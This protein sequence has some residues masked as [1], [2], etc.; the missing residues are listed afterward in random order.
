MPDRRTEELLW[1]PSPLIEIARYVLAILVVATFGSAATL[2]ALHFQPS[3]QVASDT[4]DAVLLDLPPA[5]ESSAPQRDVN[6]GPEQQA[7]Q[8]AA[9][10]APA[11]PAEVKPVPP[12]P[13]PPDPKPEPPQDPTDQKIDVAPAPRPDAAVMPPPKPPD[14]PPPD[15]PPKDDKPDLL[16][17]EVAPPLPP[18]VA[19]ATA[20]EETGVSGSAAP[21]KEA[22]PT[23][24]EAAHARAAKAI[25][26]W[27]R[28]MLGRL[29]VA[30]SGMHTGGEIGSVEVVF[31]IDHAGTIVTSRVARGSGS[32]RM[33]QAA[34]AL[35]QRASPFPRPPATL[36]ARELTFRVPIVFARRR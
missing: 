19:A 35:V 34:L 14:I 20:Q 5:V 29:Q 10:V 23:D 26:R 31:S 1:R 27:Q 22:E 6:D 2:A 32:P 36:T 16:K 21:A 13:T 11:P 7:T 8:A 24:G 4:D 33:D 17:T 28:S 30:K 18:P 15:T 9:P 25:S 3:G 12:D